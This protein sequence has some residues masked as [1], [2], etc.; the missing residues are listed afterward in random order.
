MTTTPLMSTYKHPAALATKRND[1][2]ARLYE[3]EFQG[4]TH[5]HTHSLTHSLQAQPTHPLMPHKC[6]QS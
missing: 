6:K 4:H 5:I 3:T 1:D 2:S